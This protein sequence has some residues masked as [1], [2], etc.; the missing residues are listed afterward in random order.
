[1][2]FLIKILKLRLSREHGI[3]A[4]GE[5]YGKNIRLFTKTKS[6]VYDIGRGGIED[7]YIEKVAEELK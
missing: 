1:M 2:D 3:K 5:P 7:N 6:T 4:D